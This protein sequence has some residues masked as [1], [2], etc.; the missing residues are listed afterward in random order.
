MNRSQIRAPTLALIAAA[1]WRREHTYIRGLTPCSPHGYDVRM[2]E[3]RVTVPMPT[4][5]K[6]RAKAAAS[7]EGRPL[8]NWIRAAMEDRLTLEGPR[9]EA[10]ERG[11]AIPVTV[12]GVMSRPSGVVVNEAE[13]KA[14]A[15]P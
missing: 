4:A 6:D 10:A 3:K 7:R 11:Y 1:H 5:L 2:M 8:T 9:R 15:A 13:A 12:T 14:E